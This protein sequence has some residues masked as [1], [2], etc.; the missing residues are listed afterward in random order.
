VEG[1]ELALYFAGGRMR[2][3]ELFIHGRPAP[4][5][6]KSAF[7]D[8]KGGKV[9]LAP[10]SKY[11]KAWRDTVVYTWVQSEYYREIPLEGPVSMIIVFFMLRSKSHYGTGRNAGVLKK[12]APLYPDKRP[13]L[14]K[15]IRSTEDALTNYAYK[16]DSQIVVRTASKVYG[17]EQ[18]C[19]IIIEEMTEKE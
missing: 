3:F 4:G 18:G 14:T 19:K 9:I 17:P 16:D 11:T 2:K 8:K 12:S 5:G 15:L 10:A 13:D 6:S 7:R 1:L